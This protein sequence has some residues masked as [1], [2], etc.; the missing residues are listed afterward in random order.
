[1]AVTST[2]VWHDIFRKVTLKPDNITLEAEKYDDTLNIVRGPGVN[3]GSASTST[4]TFEI[5]VD[6]DISVPVAT[7]K[8]SLEDVNG[9]LSEITLTPGRGVA[10]NR[11]SAQELEFESFSVTETDTLHTV[12]SRNNITSNKI[13]VDNI[14]VG[15]IASNSAE[16]GFTS[17]DPGHNLIGDGTLDN[18]MRFSP[19]Y[20]DSI[21]ANNTDQFEF[22]AVGP[23][24]LAY[25]ANYVFD[26]AATTGSVTLERENPSSPGSWTVLDTQSGNTAGI[27]YFI[28]GT[29][30]ELYSGAVTYRLTFAWTGNTGTA[31]WYTNDTFEGGAYTPIASP[32]FK[33]DTDSKTVNINDIQFFQNTI[34]TMSS[35]T[36]VVFDLS[37]TGQVRVLGDVTADVF[38]GNLNGNAS[39]VTNGVYT[40]GSYSNPS[41]ITSL[42]GTKITNAVLTTGSYADPSWITS[43]NASKIIGEINLSNIIVDGTI[44]IYDNIIETTVSNANLELKANGT[45]VVFI[46][47]DATITGTVSA[48]NFIGTVGSG[49]PNI[50]TFT[51]VSASQISRT[52]NINS[53]A[54]TTSGIGFVS[55]VSTFT[56]TSSS[57]TVPI[58]TINTFNQ[59]TLASTNPVTVTDAATVY[60]VN[61]PL[62]GTNTTITNSNSLYVA[63][64]ISRFLGPVT[65]NGSNVNTTI[66]PTGSGTVS[67]QPAG[68]LTLGTAGVTTTVTGNVSAITSNQTITLSPT[69]T[70]TVTI[71]P[72]TA[73]T[74]N[75]MS[76]GATTRASGNFTTL[77]A[78]GNVTLGDADTDTIT[79]GASFVTGTVFRS[80]KSNGNTLNFA[81]Y[82]V[83]GTSYT[84]LITMTASNTPTLGLVS[85][86]AMSI[87]S[88][89]AGNINNMNIG[90]TTAATG[91]F[92]TL[93]V[94]DTSAAFDVTISPASSS[95]LT[96]GRTLTVDVINSNRSIKLAGDID[97]ANN[98]TT[99]G[100]F[101]LTLTTTNTTSVTLPT[102]GTLYGTATSSIT[103]AQLATSLSD[104]TGSGVVVFGTNPTLASPAYGNASLTSDADATVDAATTSFYAY[105]QSTSATARTINISNLTA[106]RV[107]QLYLRNTFGSTKVVNIAASTT[108]SGFA[109]VNMSRGAGQTSATSVTLA[110]TSGTAMITVFNANGTFGGSIG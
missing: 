25:A 64:G 9:N 77:D 71:N 27:S 51:T 43:L 13:F 97:I 19:L 33:T 5:N 3:F 80:A 30:S 36:D 109:A 16:D 32:Q 17:Y 90:A 74:I 65:I 26:T 56:D 59:H 54:W 106:G 58:T 35:N 101:A 23:G 53:A 76:I 95:A 52:G 82:D 21:A 34:R 11:I 2:P 18:S 66:S 28:D 61:G 67:I 69:G 57:G 24:T 91:R 108:A 110:A 39:T 88:T 94:K 73:G 7:T 102:S 78:N 22:V 107:I 63:G 29:Y 6:Y 62:A 72:A 37:G 12:T 96:A 41:W 99:S 14:E 100:N 49:T 46:N 38:N 86:G 79:I 8:I 1:M 83:D 4:D 84:N 55:G 44:S 70:G 20:Q 45:G 75:N 85:I 10:I 15:T 105:I 42:A 89:A 40:T 98:L 50:G 68:I 31:T 92:S 103:S 60:I 47:D 81:A 87:S 104:E 93:A 48:A